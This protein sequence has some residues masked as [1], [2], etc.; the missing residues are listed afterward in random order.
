M[1]K[2]LAA[3]MLCVVGAAHADLVKFHDGQEQRLPQVRYENEA[4]VGP[5]G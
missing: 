4:L 2:Q 1:L 5:K 3:L